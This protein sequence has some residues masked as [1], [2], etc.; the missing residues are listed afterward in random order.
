MSLR[1]SQQ[2]LICNN[3]CTCVRH[4]LS[5]VCR[6]SKLVKLPMSKNKKQSGLGDGSVENNFFNWAIQGGFIINF[7][8][9]R[10]LLTLMRKVL[11]FM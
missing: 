11:I 6:H 5:K 2:V 1:L 4:A 8:R 9:L 7:D 3:A 10:S